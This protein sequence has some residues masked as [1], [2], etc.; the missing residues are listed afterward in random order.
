MIPPKLSL[1]TKSLKYMKKYDT[2]GEINNTR[3]D[4]SVIDP[5]ENITI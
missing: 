5:R 1:H 3:K 4:G 2:R